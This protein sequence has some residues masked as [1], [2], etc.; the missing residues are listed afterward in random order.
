LHILAV[1][2]GVRGGLRVVWTCVN[3]SWLYS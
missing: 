1:T 3:I 2:E